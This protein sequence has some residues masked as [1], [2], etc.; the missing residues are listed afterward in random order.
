MK[1]G[2]E[3]GMKQGCGQTNIAELARTFVPHLRY[4]RAEP[5]PIEGIG[6]TLYED[7]GK[8]PSCKRVIEVSPGGRTVEYAFYYDFDIQHLYDLEHA[9]V[10]LDRE[11]KVTGVESSFHGKFLNSLIEGV[12]EFEEGHPVLYVQPGKHAL[13]PAP[14]YF[15]LVIDRDTACSRNAGEA[16]FL[17]SSMFEGRL[18]T[19]EE[20]DRRIEEYIRRNHAFE[21]AWEFTEKSPDGRSTEE[22]LMPY[23]D[24]DLL[25]VQ[26]LRQWSERIIAGC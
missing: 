4:D 22:L 21:P 9:F 19:N 3:S 18:S 24:L 1:Q 20:L 12:T 8:S 2:R 17:I 25:I 6:Y 10:Y 11:G 7:R 15:K 26:R 13:L 23:E 14:E 5:F 16:G